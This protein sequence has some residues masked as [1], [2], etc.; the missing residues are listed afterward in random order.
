[1]TQFFSRLR[2]ATT[3]RPLRL[4]DINGMTLVLAA[5]TFTIVSSTLSEARFRTAASELARIERDGK[6]AELNQ[7]CDSRAAKPGE[8]RPS[9]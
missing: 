3:M 2:E 9:S 5:L 7:H 4:S 6:T 8:S 1:M